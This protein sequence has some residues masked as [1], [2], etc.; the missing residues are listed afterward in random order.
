MSILDQ[1]TEKWQPEP[2]TGCYIWIGW[3]DGSI[4]RRPKLLVNGKKRIVARLVCEEAYGPPPTVVHTDAAHNTPN[5]CLGGPCVNSD[6]I[7][8]ATRSENQLDIP[9]EIRQ[10]RVQRVCIKN[11]KERYSAEQIGLTHYET[12]RPCKHG[13]LSRR[14]TSTGKC[15]ECDRESLRRPAVEHT[16]RQANPRLTKA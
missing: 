2:N 5:G 11:R 14:K 12:G 8:W 6:H 3:E 1:H 15:L 9:I 10:K 16:R 7:R 4:R 13:H